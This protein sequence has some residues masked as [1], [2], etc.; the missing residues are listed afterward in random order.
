MRFADSMLLLVLGCVVAV[1][2]VCLAVFA[3][4][5]VQQLRT[6]TE[7]EA[8]SIARTL[9]E[10]PDLRAAVAGYSA[11]AAAPAVDELRG[12]P[13]AAAAGAVQARTG[14]LFVVVTDDRGIRLAHPDP[15]RI[16]EEVS[17]SFA[18]A[19]A[20][21]ETVS[22]ER[23]TLG[24]SARAKVPVYAPGTARP[25]GEVSVGF[26]PASVFDDLPTLLA[27]VAV[28]ALAALSIGVLVA[29]L[30]R[31]RL[32]RLTLGL[33]PEELTA[34]VQ[35]QAAVLDGV[36]D[37]VVA[38]APDGIIR[39]CNAVAE[40]MLGVNDP[41][42]ARVDA[43]GLAPALAAALD[44]AAPPPDPTSAFP[45]GERIL[46][47]D[48]RPVRRLGRDL[49][50]VFV[51]RDRTDLMALSERLDAVGSMTNALRAQRHEFANRV[52]VAAGLID[53]GRVDEAR[54]FLDELRGRGPI[55]APGGRLERIEEPL[56]QAIVGAKAIE[57]A[58]RGVQV[59]V[60]EGSFVRGTLSAPEDVGAVLGNLIDN[61]VRAA[62]SAERTPRQVEV[63]LLDDADVLA[64]TVADSG[65]GV[66]DPARLF[67]GGDD[68]T[69]AGAQAGAAAG[70]APADA[71]HG[72]GIGLPL[73]RDLARRRGGDVWLADAGG[74]QGGAVFCARLPG[75]MSPREEP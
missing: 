29:V 68:A 55:A 72:H 3:W 13:V 46:Y 52:H 61:A 59:T 41:V 64:I 40:R 20:G 67:S 74:G 38:V 5:G 31:R 42:G 33:Q 71:V 53:A 15:D 8:L 73:I 7:G 6:Q 19:L 2:A 47:V 51:L 49:G 18:A 27:G 75:V 34:L 24:E 62:L 30:L 14:A 39:V 9:S 10:D 44:P 63:E 35:Q 21:E 54:S 36:G 12:G 50:V 22:W 23:G 4:L 45:S 57:A 25:V 58:E 26:A 11:R 48:R 32:E 28:A 1:V 16:G 69:V 37:G 43:L 17:T 66:A 60:A 70:R 56:L 65:A